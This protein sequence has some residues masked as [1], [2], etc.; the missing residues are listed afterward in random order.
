MTTSTHRLPADRLVWIDLVRLIA[1]ALLVL[2]HVGMYYVSWDWHVKSAQQLAALE[3]WMR[4][5]APWRMDLLFIVSGIATAFMLRR[6]GGATRALLATRARRLL[7]PLVFG[8]AVVVPPQSYLEVVQRYGFDGGYVAFWR[9]Y[10]AGYGGFCGA[11][12]GCL[13]LPTW[14]HLW[15]L[16]YLFA[17]TL[18]A[19]LTVRPGL[20][21]LDALAAALLQALRGA[22]LLVVP[23]LLLAATRV[24]LAPRF[25]ITH[26]LV[27]DFFAHV[28]YLPMFVFGLALAQLP[29]LHEGMQ[30]LRWIALASALAAWTLFAWGTPPASDSLERIARACAFSVTQWCGIVAALG[31]ARRHLARDSA[32]RRYLTDAVFPVYILHQ[33]LTI[34]LARSLAPS[35]L[36]PALEGPLLVAGT[37]AASLAGYEI[38][39]R[40]GWMRP[41]FGLNGSGARSGNGAVRRRREA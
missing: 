1:F 14:N 22:R 12:T 39:R 38:V 30:R 3:P 9:M 16:P 29:V 41:L 24:L 5:V 31:F 37:F 21:I 11:R 25:P 10:L 33:T 27:D 35:D 34:V 36:P 26:A 13:I 19:W 23:V 15:F 20:R 7:L 18:L 17:Y 8:M 28:Q 32:A 40:I 2:Y 4:L 6:A